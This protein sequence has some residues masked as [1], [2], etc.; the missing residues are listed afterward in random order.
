MKSRPL[1]NIGDFVRVKDLAT[2][3][4]ELGDPIDAQCGWYSTLMDK[5]A[6]REYEVTKVFESNRKGHHYSYRL[7]GTSGWR[8]SEDVLEDKSDTRNNSAPE[9]T[10]SYEELMSL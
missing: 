10:F 6:G 3:K 1:Y 8:F 5:Y 7:N 4:K 9:C 2:L